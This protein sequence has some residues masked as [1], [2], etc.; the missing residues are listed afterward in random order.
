MGRQGPADEDEEELEELYEVEESSAA[1]GGRSKAGGRVLVRGRRGRGGRGR[2]TEG[3]G[4]GGLS[5]L[6][7]PGLWG[8]RSAEVGGVGR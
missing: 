8:G 1:E 3:G 5:G 7:Q 4:R 6:V 2:E